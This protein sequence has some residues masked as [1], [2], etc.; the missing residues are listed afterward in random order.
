MITFRVNITALKDTILLLKH[1]EKI[2]HLKQTEGLS[3]HLYNVSD[4]DFRSFYLCTACLA[5]LFSRVMVNK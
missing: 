2:I 4:L 1:E 3:E 5:M